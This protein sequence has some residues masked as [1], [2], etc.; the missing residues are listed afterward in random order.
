MWSS[1]GGPLTP[2]RHPDTPRV[3]TP[4]HVPPRPSKRSSLLP[5]IVPPSPDRDSQDG[6]RGRGVLTLHVMVVLWGHRGA[7]LQLR[8]LE[9]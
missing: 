6:Q 1:R 5:D 3:P 9:M 2:R 8:G 4:V 7:K